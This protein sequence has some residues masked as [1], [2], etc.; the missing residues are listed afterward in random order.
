MRSKACST[1][2]LACFCLGILAG[3]STQ[4]GTGQGVQISQLDG[5]LRVEING[6]LFTEYH[7]KDVP[8]PYFYP[9]L[10]P[11]ELA[12]TRK[13]PLEQTTNEGH[14]HPH[15]RGLWYAHSNIDGLDFWTDGKKCKIDHQKFL[16]IQSG[17]KSGAIVEQNNWVAP[18]GALVCSEVRTIRIYNRPDD[19][20]LLDFEITFQAPADKPVVF[21][22]DKDG[23]IATRV[24]ETMRLQDRNKQPGDGHIVLSTG[25]RDGETWGKQADWCDYYGPV[26]GKT[27]GVAIFDHPDNLRHPTWWHVRDYGLFAANPFGIHDFEKKPKGTGDYTLPAGQNI[28]FRYRF[29]YHRGNEA[30]A[31]VAEHYQEYAR[32]KP[33]RH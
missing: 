20:R 21:G 2:G 3:C 27:V 32:S 12:M 13:W 24:A 1:A 28:T 26:G 22:D 15:H 25:L 29:Y 19:E 6:Q 8:R 10:G 16:Q 11:D 18:D 30:Q 14:D 33:A 7:Y 5:K 23:T 4:S 31:R 9:V 17:K